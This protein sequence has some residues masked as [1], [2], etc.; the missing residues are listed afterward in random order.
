MQI[1]PRVFLS[2]PDDLSLEGAVSLAAALGDAAIGADRITILSA[3]YGTKYLESA[4]AALPRKARQACSLTMVFGV[5]T[6]SNLPHAVEELRKLRKKLSSLGF[7]S[8]AI[9]LF[10]K[11]A[12]FHTKL[13]YFKRS[14]KPVW[15]IGSA[16]ASPAITGARHEL[17]LRLTGRHELL[18]EYVNSVVDNS[19]IVE[20]VQPSPLVIRDIRSFLLHGALCYRP[21]ARVSFTFEACQINGKHRHVLQKSLAAASEVPHAD[22]QT[23]GFG[24]SLTNAVDKITD[25][26]TSALPQLETELGRSMSK[27]KF[28]HMAVET[29]YGFW[30]PAAYAEDVQNKLRAIEATSINR[31]RKFATQLERASIKLLHNELEYHV[32]GLKSFFAQHSVAIE[33]KS[34][35]KSRF[36]DFVNVRKLWLADEARLE[37]MVR[38]LHVEN[39]P[40]IWSDEEAAQKFE[41]S[42]FEDLAMRFGTPAKSWIVSVLQE[43]LKLKNRVGAESLRAALAER[44]K[45]G[46][47]DSIWWDKCT[48]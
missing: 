46:F 44:L 27:L 16:N 18:T 45:T 12:P 14:T 37:R 19:I 6:A 41:D 30:L 9:R 20:E 22:P 34:N 7:R 31:M 11:N 17:M 33:P 8:P 5:E 23:E 25:E 21:L 15:F 10:N 38:R 1:D 36:N 28:A 32:Q 47:L 43:E 42:F 40:D 35:Y 4:F 26:Q 48:Q 39:V 3:Y 2:R 24:F 29:I 13:Y